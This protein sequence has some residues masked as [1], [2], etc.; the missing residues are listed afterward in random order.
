MGLNDIVNV[1]ITRESRAVT[2]AS[3]GTVLILGVNL[4]INGRV[5][6][7][8]DA[9]SAI[10]KVVGSNTLEEAM[11]NA[12]FAQNPSVER[13]ALGAVSASKTFV[14]SGTYTAGSITAT[15]NGTTYTQTFS[16]DL[17][18]TLTALAAQIAAN[19]AVDT[20]AY[21]AGTNT[22]V[23]TPNTGYA[24]GVEFGLTGITG[25]MTYTIAATELAETYSQALGYINANKPDF[26][27]IVAATRD[28]AKQTLV[29]TWTEANKK[30]FVAASAESNIINQDSV[31]DTTS[32]AAVV[33]AQ[34][35]DRTFVVYH[36]LAATEAIDAAMLGKVLPFDPGT[37]TLAF[38]ALASITVDAITAT[39]ETNA[40]SK[41]CSFYTEIGGVNIVPGSKCG[42]D[43]FFDVIVFIDWLESR[44][45]EAVYRVLVSTKKVAFT[46]AGIYQ[47]ASAIEQ[48]LKI[49]QNRGGISPTAFD[50]NDVQIGGYNIVIPSLTSVPSADKVSR[51]LNGVSFVA[52]LAG[53]IHKVRI[54]GSVRA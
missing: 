51:T 14:F 37:Y 10:E 21:T 7:F 35:L 5:E 2:Q 38:K 40:V 26:Y 34:S 39:Q 12:I 45:T 28:V 15:V 36:S 13:I 8:E 3:F 47:I 49:G 4:N 30:V 32:I 46:T 43:E 9:D 23:V 18:G 41:N 1:V 29:A 48:P 6:Y 22:L 24:V 50:S 19:A 52:Y 42:S 20:A 33:K 54:N 27:G 11:I 25:T 17:D 44:I 16:T 53:A 31:T